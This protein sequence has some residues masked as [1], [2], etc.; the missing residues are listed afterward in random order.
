MTCTIEQT[1]VPKSVSKYNMWYLDRILGLL[2][3]KK[4]QIGCKLW[5]LPRAAKKVDE[6]LQR[7]AVIAVEAAP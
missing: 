7:G 1:T 3:L 2:L 6:P 5:W 4:V